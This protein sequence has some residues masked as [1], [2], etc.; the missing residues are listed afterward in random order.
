[1]RGRVLMIGVLVLTGVVGAA[2]QAIGDEATCTPGTWGVMPSPNASGEG[3][4]FR[5]VTAVGPE[6]VWA[7]GS[8][9]RPADHVTVPSAHHWDGGSWQ[10][11][12]APGDPIGSFAGVD[13]G[14]SDDVWAV[15]TVLHDTAG[16]RAYAMHWDGGSWRSFPVPRP[17]P[18]P[19]VSTSLSDVVTIAPDDAWAVGRWS[20]VPD[21]QAAPFAVHWDGDGWT[22]VETFDFRYWSTLFDVSATGPDDVWAVGSRSVRVDEGSVYERALALRW[23][24]AAWRAVKV[25]VVANRAAYLLESV[26]ARTRRDAWAVGVIS[27][28][29]TTDALSFHWNGERWR[30]VPTVDT[31]ETFELLADVAIQE[32]DR[33]WAVGFGYHAGRARDETVIVR[34]NGTRW[35]R[36]PSPNGGAGNELLD[37]VVLP[38]LH[39]AV[40]SYWANGGDG[41]QRTLAVR[42]C[43]G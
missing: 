16:G 42:R 4:E 19:Y 31:S 30:P 29:T 25:P 23:D 39:L 35:R 2:P 15:G 34:W 41:P 17:Q 26:D 6:D 24:G 22:V 18:G 27:R 20:P 3:N 32:R 28:A 14:S 37:L 43:A 40:G 12:P 5:S 7:V 1:M 21:G 13:A 33:A 38:S 36:V 11:H 10:L 9:L 8:Y